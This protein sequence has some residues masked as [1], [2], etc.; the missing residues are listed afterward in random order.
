MYNPSSYLAVPTRLSSRH[1]HPPRTRRWG[2][3]NPL[4]DQQGGFQ[5]SYLTFHLQFI[6]R[7]PHLIIAITAHIKTAE[8]AIFRL[9]LGPFNLPHNST[10]TAGLQEK[11][12]KA[13]FWDVWLLVLQIEKSKQTVGDATFHAAAVVKR[14]ALEPE[15]KQIGMSVP[16]WQRT[17]NTSWNRDNKLR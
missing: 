5:W 15:A 17:S 4:A 14:P 16:L 6:T 2:F 7:F 12:Q 11:L 1:L 13:P 9:A 3:S 10:A 8:V